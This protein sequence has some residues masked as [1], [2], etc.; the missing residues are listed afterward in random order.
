MGKLPPQEAR[1]L[2]VG[3]LPP[4]EARSLHVGKLPPQEAGSLLSMRLIHCSAPTPLVSRR[5]AGG[6][7][8]RASV[9]PC[10]ASPLVLPSRYVFVFV[11]VYVYV[12]VCICICT[13]ARIISSDA[14]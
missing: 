11:Y 4:Q 12:Y 9:A 13:C 7:G 14:T 1:S 8:G 10:E 3:K 5:T 6:G 2:Y